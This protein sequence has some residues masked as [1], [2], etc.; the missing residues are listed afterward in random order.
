MASGRGR[1][2]SATVGD[3]RVDA[4]IGGTGP[5]EAGTG[6]AQVGRSRL[7]RGDGTAVDAVR[8]I[9]SQPLTLQQR[10]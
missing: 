6:G 7:T 9:D 10:T 2:G 4:V 3:E 1:S 8:L 5:A